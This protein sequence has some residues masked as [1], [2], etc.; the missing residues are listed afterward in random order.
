MDT[1]LRTT[2]EKFRCPT[3]V[4]LFLFRKLAYLPALFTV[5]S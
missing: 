1:L 5:F 2:E 4:F 3:R